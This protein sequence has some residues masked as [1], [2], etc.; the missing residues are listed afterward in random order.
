MHHLDEEIKKQNNDRKCID[1]VLLSIALFP[2]VVIII[3]GAA[4]MPIAMAL[5]DTNI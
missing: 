1:I 2:T 5:L 4:A 3:T